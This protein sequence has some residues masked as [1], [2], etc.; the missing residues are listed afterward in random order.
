MENRYKKYSA[1]VLERNHVVLAAVE[2][3]AW[4]FKDAPSNDGAEFNGQS[5]SK[6]M[7]DAGAKFT[8]LTEKLLDPASTI[9]LGETSQ[10]RS[11][12]S[13]LIDA[14]AVWQETRDFHDAAL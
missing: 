8:L 11:L 13:S 14:K 4:L 1:P 2:A 3:T 12:L 6:Y 5:L 7:R 9:T 10:L